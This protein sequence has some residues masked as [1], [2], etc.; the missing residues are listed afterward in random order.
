MAHGP[1]RSRLLR[2]SY[3]RRPWGAGGRAP[4]ER[5][6]VGF[7]GVGWKGL[8]GC[9]GSLV[10]SF[11]ASPECQ[12]LA[13]CDV[14]NKSSAAAKSVIDQT[15]GNQDCAT[16]RDFRELLERPDVDAVAIATPDHWHAIQTIDACRRGKDVYCEKPLSLTIREARQ[17]VEAAR[18]YGTGR[19]DGQSEPFVSRTSGLPV[20]RYAT[21]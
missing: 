18:Q 21:A 2:C 15:Q 7:I 4:S 5:I 10:Q 19:A 12:V 8:Q 20:S 3:G 17:M 9:F 1:P 16:Y 6:T 11:L 13:A 14:N